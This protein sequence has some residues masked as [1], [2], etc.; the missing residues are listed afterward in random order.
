MS[1]RNRL[2]RLIREELRVISLKSISASMSSLHWS[3]IRAYV[4]PT[5]RNFSSFGELP[6]IFHTFHRESGNAPVCPRSF[7]ASRQ[8]S[9]SFVAQPDTERA[10]PVSYC[11]SRQYRCRTTVNFCQPWG[12]DFDHSTYRSSFV[13]STMERRSTNLQLGC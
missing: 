4:F 2:N 9:T 13:R 1:G 6:Y 10:E 12:Y 8:C 11:L 5:Y 3:T 7:Q